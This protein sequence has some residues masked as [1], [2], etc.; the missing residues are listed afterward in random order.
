MASVF[1]KIIAGDIPGR[2]VWADDLCV[3]FATIEPC[4]PG[5]ML[6]VPREEVAAFTSASPEVVSHLAQIARIIGQAQ[7]QAFPEAVRIGIVGAGFDVP[8]LHVHVIPVADQGQLELSQAHAAEA[9]ELERAT[10][11]LRV[12]LVAAGHAKNV[13]GNMHQ[14]TL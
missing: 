11:A 12:A 9:A 8:H 13:P 10:A 6:L 14:S 2:F 4:A 1:T 5:H 7:L 3:A